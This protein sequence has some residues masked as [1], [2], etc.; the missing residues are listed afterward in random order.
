MRWF[1][2]VRCPYCDRPLSEHPQEIRDFSNEIL[3]HCS[4][5]VVE[6]VE[7]GETRSKIKMWGCEA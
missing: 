5:E 3:S 4:P 7:R 2:H 6:I 1:A